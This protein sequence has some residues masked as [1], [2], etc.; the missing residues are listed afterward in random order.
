MR[1]ETS[2]VGKDHIRKDLVYW[3][4][5]ISVIQQNLHF[6]KFIFSLYSWSWARLKSGRQSRRK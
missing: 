4:K 2:K 3:A 1:D 6:S 5:E